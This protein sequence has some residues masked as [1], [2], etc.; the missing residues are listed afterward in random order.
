MTYRNTQNR[1]VFTKY[2]KHYFFFEKAI[3]RFKIL[4]TESK[5]DY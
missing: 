2:S 1:I 5:A 4:V 3:G